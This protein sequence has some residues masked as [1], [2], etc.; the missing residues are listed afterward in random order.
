M[1]EPIA[2][3]SA[4]ALPRARR[5]CS[6]ARRREQLPARWTRVGAGDRAHGVDRLERAVRVR[7]QPPV[8]C[9]ASGL[10]QESANTCWPCAHQVLDHAA[11]RREVDEVVLVD[12]R[13]HDQQRLLAHRRV[14][15]AYRISSN[16]SVRMTTAPGVA[17]MSTPTSNASAST[18]GGQPRRRG[19]V[20]GEVARAA[21]EVGAALLDRRAQRDRVGQ[22]VV[23][24]RERVVRRSRARSARG[25]RPARRAGRPRAAPSSVLAGG[26]VA[27]AAAAR[28][29]GS[30]STRRRRSGGRRA[31][32]PRCRGRRRRA[33]ARSRG[34]RRA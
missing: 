9:S 7:V 13:R 31:P 14:C 28:R 25:A 8:R 23:A 16:S 22:Q 17:A 11:L 1:I 18:L 2:S 6:R 10:R 30:R 27:A 26:E 15:G 20:A 33:R 24:R 4:A 12:H 29:P 34:R 5:A 32:A 19:H 3:S 21:H